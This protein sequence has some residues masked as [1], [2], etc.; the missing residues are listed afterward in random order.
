MTQNAV[1]G[2]DT[3]TAATFTDADR[4]AQEF[5]KNLQAVIKNLTGWR[6]WTSDGGA[7]YATR[8]PLSPV[9]LDADFARTVAADDPRELV[10]R[11][12]AELGKSAALA[13]KQSGNQSRGL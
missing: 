5:I 1:R 8:P 11:I 10:E 2:Q 12:Q 9:E 7:L 6:V 4:K 3:A 13:A